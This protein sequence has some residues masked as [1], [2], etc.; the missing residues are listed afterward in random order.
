MAPKAMDLP[1]P[2]RPMTASILMSYLEDM[3]DT[4]PIED[5]AVLINGSP[6]VNATVVDGHVIVRTWEDEL[7]ANPPC[8]DHRPIQHRDAKPPWCPECGLTAR[9][10]NPHE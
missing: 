9:W 7:N 8:P 10:E 2:P 5:N 6:I 4:Y 1:K 3:A